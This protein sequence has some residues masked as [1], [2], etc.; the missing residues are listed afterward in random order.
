MDAK[1]NPQL[2]F[3]RQYTGSNDIFITNA[4]NLL[5]FDDIIF[6][7]LKS[8]DTSQFFATFKYMINNDGKINISSTSIYPNDVE[9]KNSNMHYIFMDIVET[10]YMRYSNMFKS[11]SSKEI[12]DVGKFLTKLLKTNPGNKF[13][14]RQQLDF[15]SHKYNSYYYN[16]F[17]T[18]ER[19]EYPVLTNGYDILI[20]G[21]IK[22]L[23]KSAYIFY[24]VRG[25]D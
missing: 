9:I 25:D 16:Y 14:K 22:V 17:V 23:A 2:K 3:D 11:K 6:A 4:T 20:L 15:L 21:I 13:G 12:V 10:M 19:I 1:Y 8:N 18:K 5:E 24:K 7:K